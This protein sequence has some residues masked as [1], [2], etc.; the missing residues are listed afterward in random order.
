[1]SQT[2]QVNPA[3]TARAAFKQ[4]AVRKVAPTPDNYAKA[5]AEAAQL[6]LGEVLPVWSVIEAVA[7]DAREDPARSNTAKGIIEALGKSD[8]EGVRHGFKLLLRNAGGV[9]QPVA[10]M[11]GARVLGASARGT[12]ESETIGALR[13]LFKKTVGALIDERTGFSHENVEQANALIAL[14]EVADTPAKVDDVA[15]RLKN[16]WMRLELRDEGPTALIRHLHGLLMLLLQNVGDLAPDDQW[17]QQ[18]VGRLQESLGTALSPKALME[19]ERALKDFGYRQTS[20]RS[21]IEEANAAIRNMM[22]VFIERL[23]AVSVSTGDF[24]ARLTGYSERIRGGKDPREIAGILEHLVGDTN[25]IQ[26]DMSRTHGELERTRLKV[27]EYESHVKE[28]EGKLSVANDLV[29]EDPL[30]R[31]F[32]RRGLEQQYVVEESRSRRRGKPLALVM[33]DLDDFKK[34]NDRLGHQAGDAALRRVVEVVQQ[35]IRPTDSIA[36]YGG[37]EFVVLLPET[38]ATAGAIPINRVLR[39]LAARPLLWNGEEA[40]ITFSAGV[41]TRREN[42]TLEG[43]IARADVAMYEAKRAGKNR[44]V[45]A[46]G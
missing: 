40:S 22:A 38:D 29:R 8:W 39:E 31:A 36:R 2:I 10:A 27:A 37:E 21:S 46:G 17:I 42:E 33:L 11:D 14:T 6:R 43:L 30:T 16:F 20:T 35:L 45:I 13:A 1:M 7:R 12:S 24:S 32:N 28:L 4:L 34:L 3:L 25:M 18:E 26:A 15:A 9:S 41:V 44:V 19:A 23:G 5:Y